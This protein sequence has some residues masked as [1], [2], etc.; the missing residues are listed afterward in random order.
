[1]V[2]ISFTF[3]VKSV[4]QKWPRAVGLIQSF[5]S[6]RSLP[7]VIGR[8]G[9]VFARMKSYRSRLLKAERQV[10]GGLLPD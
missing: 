1:V 5:L 9:Y 8:I 10:S 7:S 3:Q 6:E 4:V 2:K